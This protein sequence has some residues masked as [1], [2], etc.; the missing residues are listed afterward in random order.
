[1]KQMNDH[2]LMWERDMAKAKE[3]EEK[4]NVLYSIRQNRYTHSCGGQSSQPALVLK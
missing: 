1:M 4:L 3:E 2:F